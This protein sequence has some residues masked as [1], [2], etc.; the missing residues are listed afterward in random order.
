MVEVVDTVAAVQCSTLSKDAVGLWRAD[1]DEG[2]DAGLS[3]AHQVCLYPLT[4]V[5]HYYYHYNEL[6]QGLDDHRSKN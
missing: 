5:T 6:P 1:A 2:L 4:S 3:F